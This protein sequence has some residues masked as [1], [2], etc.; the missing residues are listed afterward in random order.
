MCYGVFEWIYIVFDFGNKN[1]MII[2]M[3]FFIVINVDFVMCFLFKFNWFLFFYF[4]IVGLKNLR[5]YYK[6][7][8]FDFIILIF[9]VVVGFFD[10]YKDLFIY[11]VI[12]LL[13]YCRYLWEKG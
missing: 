6:N 12:R 9:F 8:E 1:K 10:V 13:F 7:K 3:F 11:Y 2:E 4:L 5:E